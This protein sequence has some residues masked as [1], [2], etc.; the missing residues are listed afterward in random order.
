MVLWTASLY[1][2]SAS[3]Q[4]GILGPAVPLI[5]IFVYPQEPLSRLT[6]LVSVN[7]LVIGLSNI[8]WV[9]L[10]NTFGRRP[11][12]ILAL[13]IMTFGA[14]WAG[15]AT[16]FSSLLAARAIQGFGG[17]PGD[18]IAPDMIGECFFVHQRGR[19]MAFYTVFLAGG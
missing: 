8:I 19:A 18:S 9:P 16:S 3:L 17:G 11:I 2:F 4:S 14:M 5:Q 13:L 7:V 12:L 10:A 1:A 15:I 6:Q